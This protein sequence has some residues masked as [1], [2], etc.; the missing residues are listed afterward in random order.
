MQ[1]I[2]SL[3]R[4]IKT[5]YKAEKLEHFLRFLVV[6]SML[7]LFLYLKYH[8]V[9]ALY[10][11]CT[12]KNIYK[13]VKIRIFSDWLI[14]RKLLVVTIELKTFFAIFLFPLAKTQSRN[15]SSWKKKTFSTKNRMSVLKTP[16]FHC[17]FQHKMIKRNPDF[18]IYLRNINF[19]LRKLRNF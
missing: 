13:Y 8:V 1:K 18:N 12:I 7:L 6:I 2:S 11:S 16:P 5:L 14:Q 15:S 17:K 4:N 10:I 3:L 9:S 19:Y